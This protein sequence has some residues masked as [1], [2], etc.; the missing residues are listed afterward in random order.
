MQTDFSMGLLL[1]RNMTT[2]SEADRK[3]L[4]LKFI[5]DLEKLLLANPNASQQSHFA[6]FGALSAKSTLVSTI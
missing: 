5:P 1:Q 3:R 2:S 6:H 4:C